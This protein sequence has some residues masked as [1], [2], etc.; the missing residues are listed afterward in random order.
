[1]GARPSAG[2]ESK[3]CP[4]WRSTA[5]DGKGDAL[6]SSNDCLASQITLLT[7]VVKCRSKITGGRNKARARLERKT[8]ESRLRI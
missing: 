7:A 2:G 1:M 3:P 6:V 4:R 8:G 5:L